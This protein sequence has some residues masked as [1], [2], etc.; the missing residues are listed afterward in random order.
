MDNCK[1][2]L[3]H[4]GKA[5]TKNN[6][7]KTVDLVRYLYSVYKDFLNFDI[8]TLIIVFEHT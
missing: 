8:V 5:V 2:T 6:I 1:R 4:L 7:L 3:V